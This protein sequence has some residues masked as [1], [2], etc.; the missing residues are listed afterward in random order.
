MKKTFEYKVI[1]YKNIDHHN[2]SDV[3]ENLSTLGERGFEL[4]FVLDMGENNTN[5]E[6][7]SSRF[8]YIFKRKK[9]GN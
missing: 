1:D 6:G 9:N 5:K 3:Q 2:N 8:R 4:V 7:K